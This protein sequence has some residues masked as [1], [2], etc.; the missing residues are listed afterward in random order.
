MTRSLFLRGLA[1]VYFFAFLSLLPQITGL[2]GEK[3]ILPAA[4]YL[5]HIR[6]AIGSGA[7]LAFPTLAWF[8]SSDTFLFAM[9]WAGI[10]FAAALFFRLVP[11]VSLVAL[12]V[13][14]LSIVVAGQTFFGFQWDALLL[15]TGFAAVLVTP[16]GLRPDYST[17]TSP[18][19]VWVLRFLVFRL[20]LESGLVKLLSGDHTWRDLTALTF[21]YE[22]QPLPTPIAWYAHHLPTLVH[23]MSALGV[24]A[25]ELAVPFLFFMPRPFRRTG[26]WITIV[27]Q[28]LIAA[29]GNYTFFNLLTIVL[30]IPLFD[31]RPLR[32]E[33]AIRWP[34]VS[35]PVAAALAIVGLLQLLG[36]A[37]LPAQLPEPLASINDRAQAFQVVNRYGLFAIMTTSRP[38][39]VIEGSNDGGEWKEYEFK[40]K[41]GTVSRPLP[42]VAPYQP[43]LDWQMWFAALSN[44]ENAP[45]F[46]SFVLRLLE[47][48]PEV[49]ALLAWNPFP[50]KPPRFIRASLYDYRFSGAERRSTGDIW[51]RRYLGEYFPVVGLR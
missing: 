20:M 4:G 5:Q 31:D 50:D 38:E 49:S 22:T 24:F 1:L 32:A 17:P 13:L 35:I 9:A 7:Y 46:S 29:T 10:V 23:Q 19:G 21:H 51:S 28:L 27:F 48:S 18:V 11:F 16:F 33:P 25:I 43:R 34:W 44:H 3:G 42:W 14:Y 41:P 26:A 45:W 37:G 15:E 8:N 47:G 39:I 12:Y 6:S 36:M 2:I 40:Y 30:C